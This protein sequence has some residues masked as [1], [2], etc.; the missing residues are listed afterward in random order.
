MCTTSDSIILLLSRLEINKRHICREFAQI[1]LCIYLEICKI[2]AIPIT[3]FGDLWSCDVDPTL[4][5][6]L[7]DRW[8]TA[9]FPQNIFSLSGTH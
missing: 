4:S 7:A 3:G 2:K 1:Y 8:Q 5:R 9:L 6:Q